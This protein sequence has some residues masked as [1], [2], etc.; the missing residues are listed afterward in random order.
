MTLLD[1]LYAQAVRALR[2]PRAAAADV[3]ALGVPRETVLPALILVAII[4]VFLDTALFAVMPDVD[5]TFAPFRS[6]VFYLAVAGLFAFVISF[7]GKWFQGV[8]SIADALL[9]IVFLQAMLL[10]AS[11]VQIVLALIS[12]QLAVLFIYLVALFLFWIQ[13]NFVAALHGFNTLGRAFAVTLI[14]SFIV[15][16]FLAPFF[17]QSMSMTDV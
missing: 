13:V 5:A 4:S 14:A 2:E 11:A 6:I 12:P 1:S 16:F 7:V 8:G 9:L 3:L 15:A 10:P 17:Q